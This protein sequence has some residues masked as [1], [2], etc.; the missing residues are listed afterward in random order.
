MVKG[1]RWSTQATSRTT[2]FA[3]YTSATTHSLQG[4]TV[5]W[6]SCVVSHNAA[7]PDAAYNPPLN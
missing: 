2:V 1:G 5:L 3:G 4:D 7:E 6:S